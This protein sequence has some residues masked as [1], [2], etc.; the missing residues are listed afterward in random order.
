M[1]GSILRAQNMLDSSNR[2]VDNEKVAQ[3]VQHINLAAERDSVAPYTILG[4]YLGLLPVFAAL[5]INR[6][7][8]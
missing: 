4:I 3:A 1:D 2:M 7:L 8:F 5:V 6:L